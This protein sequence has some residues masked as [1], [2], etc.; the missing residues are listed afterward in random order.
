[1]KDKD[2]QEHLAALYSLE[3]SEAIS[4]GS[5]ES[6][7][8]I[9][10]RGLER[11]PNSL[12]INFAMGSLKLENRDFIGARSVYEELLSS[13]DLESQLRDMIKNNI[14]W[15]DLYL[16]EEE[17]HQNAYELVSDVYK[18]NSQTGWAN[19][20]LGAAMVQ[21]GKIR[22][23]MGYLSKAFTIN[24]VDISLAHNACWLSVAHARLGELEEAH[25]YLEEGRKLHPSSYSIPL[26][27]SEL[28]KAE[29]KLGSDG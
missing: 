26:A 13:D 10:Q 8:E 24:D 23:G 22:D 4:E 12:V 29:A 16:E 21:T 15:T 27:E 17:R 11:Y 7:G 3:I 18:R 28:A 14:A 2:F 19:G 5:M 6:A 25:R 20:T 9:L 1:M